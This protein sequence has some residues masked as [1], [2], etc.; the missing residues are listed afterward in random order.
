MEYISKSKQNKYIKIKMEY[1][2][3]QIKSLASISLKAVMQS[4]FP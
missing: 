2:N 4:R 3:I 1:I